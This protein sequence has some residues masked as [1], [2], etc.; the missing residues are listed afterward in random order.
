MEVRKR[1]NNHSAQTQLSYMLLNG[2]HLQNMVLLACSGVSGPLISKG[3]PSDL[4]RP[5]CMIGG[6]DGFKLH[7]FLKNKQPLL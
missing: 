6:L 4:H 1:L 7:K 5:S 3:H 2:M